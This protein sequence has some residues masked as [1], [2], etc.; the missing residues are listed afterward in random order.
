MACREYE[1]EVMIGPVTLAILGATLLTSAGPA[2]TTARPAE[3]SASR[4]TCEYAVDP[5][6]VDTAQPRFGWVLKS[7][8]RGQVQS[9]YQILVAGSAEEL[10]AD[11]GDKWDSGK[12]DSDRSV[13]VD[14]RGKALASGEQCYWKVRVW[15]KQGR[16]SPW[17]RPGSF[18]M[19]LME[20]SDWKGKWI[21]VAPVSPVA[22]PQDATRPARVNVALAAKPTTSFV[23]GHETLDAINDGFEP[24]N[25]SDK[26]Y[27][28]YGNWP[29]K[30]TQWVQYEWSKPVNFAR[31]DV[32]W[33]SDGGGVQLPKA[34]RLLY[35]DGKAFV[36]VKN[37]AGLGVE[38]NK[39]LS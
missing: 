12:V 27:G 21:G 18:E 36:P 29:Q 38:G 31:I 37:P 9:A 11:A 35:W 26:H 15:D 30:G 19:G 2:E 3:L 25:S 14:Y 5:L 20:P 10:R 23:S 6:G 28:A 8:T 7:D 39:N 17:S 1:G 13:N 33:F 32:Y 4:L 22:A 34:S 16:P 24:A